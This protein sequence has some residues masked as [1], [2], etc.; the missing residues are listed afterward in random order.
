MVFLKWLDDTPHLSIYAK[1][2]IEI[3][4]ELTIDYGWISNEE[5][6]KTPMKC[7]CKSDKCRVNV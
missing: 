1:A 7:S 4:E 6:G 2:D 5:T 3:G